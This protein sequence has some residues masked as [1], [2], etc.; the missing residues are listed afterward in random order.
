MLALQVYFP[1]GHGVNLNVYGGGEMVTRTELMEACGRLGGKG[2]G[3]WVDSDV[4]MV[5]R[6]L[7]RF[8]AGEARGEADRR[9]YMR[10]YMRVR[11]ARERVKGRKRR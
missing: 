7:E 8:L 11:R 9:T 4:V 6:A 2:S 5:V 3:G 1:M 10:E